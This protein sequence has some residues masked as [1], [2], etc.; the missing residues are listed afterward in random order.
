[1]PHWLFDRSTVIGL[2]ILGGVFSIIASLCLSRGWITEQQAKSLN[3]AA[4]ACMG[5]SMFLFIGAG[6]LGVGGRL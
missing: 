6:L 3:K 2:A 4:Y 5:V 1:M